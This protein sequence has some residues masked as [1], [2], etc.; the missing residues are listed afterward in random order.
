M[1][2]ST[3]AYEVI[4]FSVGKVEG[5]RVEF[6][7]HV[8][9]GK[10]IYVNAREGGFRGTDFQFLELMFH[11]H[12]YF[13]KP[14]DKILPEGERPPKLA[15]IRDS[16]IVKCRNKLEVIALVPPEIFAEF[17][18]ALSQKARDLLEEALKIKGIELAA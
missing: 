1:G 16:G 8:P 6:R 11:G 2:D 17:K 4:S 15:L 10:E 5:Q 18:A 7:G 12:D 3:F 13:H 9:E 14:D